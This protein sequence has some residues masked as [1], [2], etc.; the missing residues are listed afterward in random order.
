VPLNHHLVAKT[1]LSLLCIVQASATIAI[2]L[3]RTHVQILGGQ[4]MHGSISYGR[5][6]LSY[7]FRC[8]NSFLYGLKASTKANISTWPLCSRPYRHWDF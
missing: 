2:D 7:F 8:S 5:A 6:A 3:D 1:A 4:A